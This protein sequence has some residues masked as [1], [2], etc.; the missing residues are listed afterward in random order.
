MKT[1]GKEPSLF[2]ILTFGFVWVL[3]NARFG[4]VRVVADQS[5]KGSSS[6]RVL[7]SCLVQFLS[8]S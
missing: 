6:V 8:S 7:N 5:T 3:E 4:S 2:T 1:I